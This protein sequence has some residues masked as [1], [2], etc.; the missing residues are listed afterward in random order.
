MVLDCI[1]SWSLPSFLL[2]LLTW[3][4][5]L[6]KYCKLC[7]PLRTNSGWLPIRCACFILSLHVFTWSFPKN[8]KHSFI[9]ELHWTKISFSGSW[10]RIFKNL[11]VY[12][13]YPFCFNFWRWL[14][15]SR[16][17]VVSGVTLLD[18]FPLRSVFSGTP[19]PGGAT[20][21]DWPEDNHQKS[22][23]SVSFN[24]SRSSL[25]KGALLL[26]L[27]IYLGNK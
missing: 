21:G 20:A 14:Y 16:L 25:L 13:W 17:T 27:S 18:F 24:L 11:K 9:K 1:D 10:I 23:A 3:V 15:L 26:N 6:K 5:T 19:P 12:T 4:S 22:L 2:F 8:P 7:Y